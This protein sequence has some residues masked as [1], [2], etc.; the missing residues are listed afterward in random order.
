M[1]TLGSDKDQ[2]INSLSLR[3]NENR[4]WPHIDLERQ[5]GRGVDPHD[6]NRR[7]C[8]I[9]QKK[10]KKILMQMNNSNLQMDLKFPTAWK[11]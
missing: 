10:Q 1:S 3:K 8:C 11:W 9:F 6:P 4:L 2:R 7:S 5:R